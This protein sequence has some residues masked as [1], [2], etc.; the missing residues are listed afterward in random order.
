VPFS[1]DDLDRLRIRIGTGEKTLRALSDNQFTAWLRSL[2]AEGSM[3]VVKTAPG[4]FMTPVEDRIRI[5]NDLEARGFPI[6]G[7][8]APADA[9]PPQ[10]LQPDAEQLKALLSAL[11]AAATSIET[12]QGLA[13][14]LGEID[15]RV[16]L[17][18]SL[19]GALALMDAAR[20]AAERALRVRE[21]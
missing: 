10:T 2:G 15:S 17:R 1:I 9:S 21:S 7:I 11:R 12:A 3:T 20:G 14:D 8:T 4:R 19:A 16:N 5:L 18:Q 6:P 13:Q